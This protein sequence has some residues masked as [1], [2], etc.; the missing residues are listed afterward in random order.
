MAKRIL[1]VLT[2]ADKTVVGTTTG[3][4]LPEAAHPY[5]VLAP[6]YDIDFASPKGPN[7]P[8]DPASIEF[9]KEDANKFLEDP[10]VKDKLA[11][12][13]K[14][15]DVKAADYD[16]V[17][18]VGGQGPVIDLPTDPVNIKLATG[19]FR[20]GKPIAAICHGPAALV[21][22]TDAQG[23]NIFKGR[24]ATAISNA[25]DED[26]KSVQNIPWLVETRIRELGGIYEKASE[27]WGSHVT[28]DGNLITGE[29]PASGKALGEAIDRA[30]S[31]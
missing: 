29:N 28:V 26:Y 12:A 27:L 30:L 8:L 17:F 5:Y 11:N 23:N 18:Y 2:S 6:K 13:K 1:F 20:S 19:F 16:A 4:Y 10:V 22:V 15:D 9:F 31:A 24:R 21:G 14:L 3:W 7:P 25:E